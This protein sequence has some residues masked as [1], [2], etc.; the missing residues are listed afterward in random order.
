MELYIYIYFTLAAVIAAVFFHLVVTQDASKYNKEFAIN[1]APLTA[2][3]SVAVGL[4]WP[5]IVVGILVTHGI[6]KI[7]EAIV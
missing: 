3:L 2:L 5:V 1:L 7:A 4:L 6:K